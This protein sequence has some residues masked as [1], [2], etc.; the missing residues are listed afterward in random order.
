MAGPLK[1]LRT[2]KDDFL[3]VYNEFVETN[4]ISQTRMAKE[5]GIKLSTIR[6]TC[7]TTKDNLNA[8]FVIAFCLKYRVVSVEDIY[9][10]DMKEPEELKNEE[11]STI[12]NEKNFTIFRH[13]FDC[14]ELKD[15]AFMGTFYGYCRNTQYHDTIDS[16]VLRIG[17]NTHNELQ[18]ELELNTHNRKREDVKKV[19]YGK[20][21]HLEPNII[22]IVCQS[23][24][25]DD[26]FILS[27]NY[28][29]IN[30]GN[31]LY[32]RFGSL[33]TP[34]RSTDRYPQMQPFLLLGNPVLQENM[35][36]VSGFLNLTQDKIIVPADKY[37]AET[38]GLMATNDTVREFFERCKDMHY[39][40]EEYYAFSEKV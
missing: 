30:S 3:R 23:N 4:H 21:M 24:R 2:A 13:S 1:D 15:P 14:H 7:D 37:D 32:C 27:Y 10:R 9:G 12:S 5:L 16:F 8:N 28:F 33:M 39:N 35:D 38:N 26:I 22:Y 17:Y 6:D 19:L 11:K 25:G 34:C 36:Y 20:P 29:K 18:A 31:K 40:K